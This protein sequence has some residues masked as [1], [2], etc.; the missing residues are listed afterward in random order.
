MLL[1]YSCFHAM[2]LEQ[3]TIAVSLY[4]AQPKV[5]VF[6]GELTAREVAARTDVW[7]GDARSPDGTVVRRLL[8]GE[9]EELS[10]ALQALR[11]ELSG[12][13]ERPEVM[14]IC[15]GWSNRLSYE[16]VGIGWAVSCSCDV[17][18]GGEGIQEVVQL[19]AKLGRSRALS[20]FMT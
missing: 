9:I 19:L 7:N 12:R 6:P 5:A 13:D 2:S 16:A 11:L 15:D 3:E 17:L 10:A 14:G 20:R 8:P 18:P 1:A 4:G